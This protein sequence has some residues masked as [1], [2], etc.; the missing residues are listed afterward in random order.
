VFTVL[1]T[2]ELTV[3]SQ[4]GGRLELSALSENSWEACIYGSFAGFTAFS[5]VAALRLR[6]AAASPD[7]RKANATWMRLCS[8][9]SDVAGLY[10][11][12]IRIYP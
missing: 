12:Q 1:S 8:I 10:P 7:P 5:I 9:L 2:A 3:A 11:S 4:M 6:G